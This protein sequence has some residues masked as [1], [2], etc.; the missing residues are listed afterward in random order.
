MHVPLN[1]HCKDWECNSD[2]GFIPS[3][4]AMGRSHVREKTGT[5]PGLENDRSSFVRS[6][7]SRCKALV[8]GFGTGAKEA[9]FCNR[10]DQR[11]G[12]G[13]LLG[14]F[15]HF[16]FFYGKK[17]V[18]SLQNSYN[19]TEICRQEV[20]GHFICLD[21]VMTCLLA[22]ISW[23]HEKKKKETGLINIAFVVSSLFFLSALNS[24]I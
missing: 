1:G 8:S 17:V 14:C 3:G 19:S 22:Y 2:R 12:K 10:G 5:C 20:G 6:G 15:L 16:S 7:P 24:H 23:N 18:L 11:R 13:T 9:A 21:A 4:S